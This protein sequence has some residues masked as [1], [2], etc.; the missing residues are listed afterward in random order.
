M[1]TEKICVNDLGIMG[2]SENC[3]MQNVW[4]ENLLDENKDYGDHLN[5]NPL[6]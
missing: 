6:P 1:C 5:P 2:L 3:L 4:D